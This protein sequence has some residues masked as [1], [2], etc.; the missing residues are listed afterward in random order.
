[1]AK[2]TTN[3]GLVK[4]IFV[5]ATAPTNI[6]VIWYDTTENL[7]KSYNISTGQ[8]EPMIE[9]VLIDNSTIK[10]DVDGKLYVDASVLPGYVLANGSVTL[11]KMANVASGTIFYRKTAGSGP[12]EVQ[13]LAQLKTD[14]GLQGENTGD[15]DLS[16]YALKSYRINNKLLNGD[17]N[18]T[19]EDIGSPAGSG[20]STNTNTGDE[21]EGSILGKLGL[22]SI[23][24]ENTGDQDAIHVPIVDTGDLF[25]ASNVED[26]LAEVMTI[27]KTLE[28]KINKT[29]HIEEILLPAYSSVSLRCLNAV[30]GTDY[31][32]GWVLTTGLSELDLKVTHNLDKKFIRAEVFEI[33]GDSTERQLSNFAAAYTGAVQNSKNEILIEGL[34]LVE[35]PLRIMLTFKR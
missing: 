32:E 34:S 31:P 15:Q 11:L 30:E 28:S 20:N 7:L 9:M 24:G 5:S 4:A 10:K 16:I 25:I 13:T 14:L 35:L 21:T 29:E 3:V 6:Y 17:I 26:A 18:L 8:W 27:V 23:S 33:N 12:P 19:P 22:N 1:M 2:K